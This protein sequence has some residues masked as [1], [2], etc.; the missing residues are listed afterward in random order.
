MDKKT[1]GSGFP[2]GFLGKK[3][4]LRIALITNIYNMSSMYKLS[5]KFTTATLLLAFYVSANFFLSSPS[6][7][8]ERG[9]GIKNEQIAACIMRVRGWNSCDLSVCLSVRPLGLYLLPGA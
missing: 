6:E 2:A 9:L 8:S 3:I 1:A 5:S 7:R 4:R